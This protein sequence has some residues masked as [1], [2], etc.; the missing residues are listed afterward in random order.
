MPLKDFLSLVHSCAD[1]LAPVFKEWHTSLDEAERYDKML[2]EKIIE[3]CNASR[4]MCREQ[5]GHNWR[6]D[7]H[8]R[9]LQLEGL[10]KD[11]QNKKKELAAIERRAKENIEKI[12]MLK[13]VSEPLQDSNETQTVTS[14]RDNELT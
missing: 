1:N 7:M 8:N 5:G 6:V 13:C 3:I 14:K 11:I 12:Y 9:I 2:N 4:E 10:S